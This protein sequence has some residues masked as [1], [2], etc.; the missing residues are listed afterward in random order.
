MPIQTHERCWKSQADVMT[1]AL[2]MWLYADHKQPEKL[3]ETCGDL[4]SAIRAAR[5]VL[6]SDD[7]ACRIDIWAR[8]QPV[9]RVGRGW[10]SRLQGYLPS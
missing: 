2:H 5:T 6:G 4:V 8:D 1:Q 9:C 10:V 7:E 3:D